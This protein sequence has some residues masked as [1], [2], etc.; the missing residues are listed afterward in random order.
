MYPLESQWSVTHR[1]NIALYQRL[2]A[3]TDVKIRFGTLS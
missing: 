1:E 3:E 2:L